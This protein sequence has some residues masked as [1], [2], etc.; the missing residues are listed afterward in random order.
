MAVRV[1]PPDL[2][3]GELGLG[4]REQRGQAGVVAAVVGDL[5]DVDVGQLERA[6]DL[7]LGIGG[8]QH[9][10]APRRSRARPPRGRWDCRPARQPGGGGGGQS[11]RRRMPPRVSD[12]PAWAGTAVLG[13]AALHAGRPAGAA[14]EDEARLERG[15]DV[16][17]HALVIRLAR[18]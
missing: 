7:G 8:Q 4:A 10:E 12:W 17:R 5:E 14:V 3:R 15:D 16:E 2:D 9:V 6:G 1:L 13:S 11:S 18:G